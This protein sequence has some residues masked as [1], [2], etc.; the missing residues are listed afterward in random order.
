VVVFAPAVALRAQRPADTLTGLSDKRPGRLYR[1][2]TAGALDPLQFEELGVGE[3]HV[4][5]FHEQFSGVLT[6][7]AGYCILSY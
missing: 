3:G 1:L 7:P 6:F 2:I 4:L 5:K